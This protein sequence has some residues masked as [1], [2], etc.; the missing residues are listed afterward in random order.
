MKKKHEEHGKT[1]YVTAIKIFFAL[2]VIGIF[3]FLILAQFILPD[4]REK[5]RNECTVFE[6]E[7]ERVL[8][9]GERIPITYPGKVPAEW[10]EIVTIVT[11]IPNDIGE[12]ESIC[13]S[14]VW[15]D[16]TIFVGN[17]QRVRY[18]TSDSRP[19]GIN[20]P[21]RNIFVHLHN[22]DAGKELKL[23]F[24]SNSKY[25]G[26]MRKAYLGVPFSIWL[27]FLLV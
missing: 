25:A 19:F 7:W 20:S 18:D 2:A 13:F 24:S 11:Q 21:Q 9:N 15:Q 16:V 10:G 26:D 27:S 23:C 6:A 12:G 5:F 1:R 17:E 14:P 8:E 4:E 22:A 3:G